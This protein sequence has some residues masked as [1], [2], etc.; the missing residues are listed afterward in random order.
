MHPNGGFLAGFL[1]ANQRRMM[2]SLP[3]M[4]DKDDEVWSS[5]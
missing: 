4:S 1:V 3:S 5:L 2:R